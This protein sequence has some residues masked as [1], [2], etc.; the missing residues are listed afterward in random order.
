[1]A[2]Q[3]STVFTTI[4][5]EGGL[6]PAD[7]LARVASQDREVPGVRPADFH[8]VQ[9]ELLGERI[10]RSWNR[11]TGAWKNFT[12]ALAVLPHDDAG[13]TLTRERWLLPLFEELGYGRLQTS[14]AEEVDGRSYPISHAWGHAPIHLVSARIP[15]DRRTAGVKGAAGASPHSLVQELLN[16]ST[17][18]LWAFVSNGLQLRVLRDNAS[19]TRQAFVEFDLETMF[20]DEVFDDFVVLWLTCHQSRVEAIEPAECWLEQWTAAAAEAGTRARDELRS[21]VE[22]AIEALGA[23]F[24]AHPASTTLRERLRS[25]EL[26]TFDYYRQLLRLIYRL[27]FLFVAEDRDLLHPPGAGDAEQR[28]YARYYSLSHIRTLA[29]RRRGGPHPDL[30][31]SLTV[32]FDGLG[33]PD[34]ISELGLPG[35]GSF[36]WSPAACP[37]LDRSN[38]ANQ[39]LMAAVRQL[40]FV[41]DRDEKVLRPVDYRNLGTEELGAIYESLLEQHP[42]V[43][44]DAGTFTLN[45]AA[46]NERKTTGSYY[47]PT[48][49]ITELLDSAVDPVV[50]EAAAKPNADEAILDLRV[51]DPACGS[52]H[53]LIAA[54]HRISKKLAAIRT[55]DDEPAPDAVRTALR[56]VIARCIHGIDLNP[57]AVELCKVSLWMES[58]EPGKPLGFLDHRIVRGNALI[59]ATPDLLDTGIP[60]EAFKKIGDDVPAIVTSLRKRNKTAREGQANLF[61]GSVAANLAP[62]ATAVEDLDALPDN[63]VAAVAVKAQRWTELVTSPDY[64]AA[65]HAADTWCAAFVAGKTPT[66]PAVTHEEFET[67][68]QHPTRVV[69]QVRSVV[70]QL[71]DQYAFL[72]WHL[73]FPDV[74]ASRGGFDLVLG[75]PPWEK[76]KLSEKEFF[77][78]RAPEVATLAGAKRKAAIEKLQ[79]DDPA[80]WTE[81]RFSLRQ[82]EGESHFIRGSGR[83]PL[84]GRGDVNTYAIFAE[85]MRDVLG[86]IGRLGVILPTGIAT[87]DTTKH[88]FADIV[89]RRQLASLLSF[90]NEAFVFP[91]VHH[92]FKFCL[93]CLSGTDR[94]VSE[95]DF[96]FFARAVS[97]LRDPER[98]FTLTTDDLALINPNTKT[99]P[100]FRT[101]RD[102]E[103]T[104]SIYRR[105]AVLVRDNDPEGNP[106]GIEYQR[107]FDMTNDS[108]LFRTADEL[109][110]EGATL[111][112]N[113]WIRGT[114]RWLPLY[115]AKMAHQF[116]HRFGD[117]ALKAEDDGGSALPDPPL[118]S[119]QDPTYVVQPRYWVGETE[120]R[121]AMRDPQATWLLGFRDITNATNERTMIATALPLSAIGNNEP[122]LTGNNAR[123]RG[124]LAGVLSSFAHDFSARP[125]VGGTHINFF[126][127]KQL[128][129]PS[130]TE[131]DEACRWSGGTVS[132]WIR[133]R[134][135]ELIYTA[136]DLARFAHEHGWDGPPFRW[137]PARRELLRAEL[138]AAFFHLYGI[139]RDDVGYIMDTFPI[140]C[141]KDEAAHGEY[142]TKRLILERYDAL[143]EA[144]ANG[145]E[146]QTVLD[147]PPA[148]PRVAHPESSR[149]SWA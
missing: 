133:P 37:D 4:R 42:L 107:M 112:G 3:R 59:G 20:A 93:L 75:N 69:P 54:A 14:R 88:F 61:G 102:A 81:Y 85:A 94:P 101:R 41:E 32:V 147:P 73:A 23:G 43:N 68:Q 108:H 28:R 17:G 80:L 29:G 106:W 56:D 135:V 25:G 91:G 50:A 143:A 21:G 63:D 82:A 18:H 13:T 130:P 67:A 131:F 125:K 39:H 77:A 26:S 90:E 35:L 95:A 121:G 115:E 64:Q 138:D 142:R 38:I 31:R 132:Q 116:N 27:L 137:D 1:M 113:V 45:T 2:R 7:L 22:A 105:V 49:L 40:G 47:T 46:G 87:D 120:V 33:R 109:H 15:L 92:A 5:T 100:V 6:L 114:H 16:R 86:P 119:I 53:F 24:V 124:L 36:L 111:T 9:G 149:P 62:I 74:F 128:A 97:D 60:D 144:A 118:S 58:M 8:L 146:Y 48:S 55:G 96:F 129:V 34:G 65:V 123:Q 99:A 72:H 84:C 57:M 83:Y 98:R 11:L 122:L 140:V 89:D 76:V 127:A 136:W 79:V 104:K 66:A 148:D 44:A 71:A 78:S 134:L 19:L 117:Y 70:D 139:E 30:W 10:T 141:R 52:G 126:I 103:I 145:T 110:A 12:T 51:I